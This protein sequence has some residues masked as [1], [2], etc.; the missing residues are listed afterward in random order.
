MVEPKTLPFDLSHEVPL[1]PSNLLLEPPN[2]L[3]LKSNT[4]VEVNIQEKPIDDVF[5]ENTPANRIQ[6]PQPLKFQNDNKH[7]K[8]LT[9]Q[10]GKLFSRI[11]AANLED[12]CNTKIREHDEG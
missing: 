2:L 4:E 7:Q 12:F 9:V 8:N 5:S 11:E 3:N 1:E 10:D 6:R